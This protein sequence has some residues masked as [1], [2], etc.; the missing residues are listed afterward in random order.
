MATQELVDEE[1]N[2]LE[3][4]HA[5]RKSLNYKKAKKAVKE[6]S[7]VEKTEEQKKLAK[8]VKIGLL[9]STNSLGIYDE[10]TNVLYHFA[11]TGMKVS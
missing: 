2:K 9:A 8:E 5:K 3:L 1:K 11:N 10:V 6:Q 7:Q 4:K